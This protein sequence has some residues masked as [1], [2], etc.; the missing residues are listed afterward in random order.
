MIANETSDMADM[1]PSAEVVGVDLS[2]IQPNFIPP[3]CRFEVDD[4]N[5]EW[6]FP[7]NKFDFIHI[8]YMT[9]TVPSWP[10]LLK[11]AQRYINPYHIL[12]TGLTSLQTS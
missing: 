7:E 2:P 3:N 11:K 1:H 12:T 4:I 9:G 10:E 8:R 5:K 6:T